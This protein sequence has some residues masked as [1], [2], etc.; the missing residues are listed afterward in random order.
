MEGRD[1]WWK[2]KRTCSVSRGTIPGKKVTVT[3]WISVRRRL[4]TRESRSS[5]KQ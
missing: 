1:K 3:W 4:I 2:L 5:H